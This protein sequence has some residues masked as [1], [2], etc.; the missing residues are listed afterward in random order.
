MTQEQA[1][2]F[3][4]EHLT[5]QHYKGLTLKEVRVRIA[6]EYTKWMWMRKEQKMAGPPPAEPT[7]G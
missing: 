7:D 5:V 4:D 3:F 6:R 1:D 2:K